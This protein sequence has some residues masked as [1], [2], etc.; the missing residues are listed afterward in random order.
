[1]VLSRF[2]LITALSIGVAAV[3]NC[4]RTNQ[5]WSQPLTTVAQIRRLSPSQLRSGFRAHLQGT[6]TFAYAS[7]DTCYAQDATGGVRVQLS[8]GQMI[9]EAGRRID[10]WGTVASAGDTPTLVE[11]RFTL[12]GPVPLPP[13]VP[14]RVDASRV[15]DLSFRRVSVTGVVQAAADD[16]TDLVI[17][18]VK[19]GEKLIP[20][21]V[22]APGFADPDSYI[23]ADIRINGVL[24]GLPESLD[25]GENEGLLV[26]SFADAQMVSRSKSPELV[27]VSAIGDLTRLRKDR[28][29]A[30]RVRVRGRAGL[31]SSNSLSLEDT[32][33]RITVL[34]AHSGLKQFTGMLD[35]TGFLAQ[36]GGEII[37]E[38]AVDA[39]TAP[40]ASDGLPVLH[41]ARAIHQLTG[42]QSLLRYPA[43]VRGVVTFTDPFNGILFVQDQTDGIFVSVDDDRYGE[44][45]PG[46]F[47]EV[48]G[49]TT[50]GGFAP[51]ITRARYLRL[52]RAAL[53]EPRHGELEDAFLGRRDCQWIELRGVI[54]SAASGARETLAYLVSGTHRVQARIRAEVPLIEPLVNSLVRVRGVCGALFNNRRQ[55]LGIV[56]YVPGRDF[57]QVE[58][59]ASK[60]PFALPVTP[61]ER[62]LQF[63]PE[64]AMGYRVRMRGVAT[65]T[66]LSGPTWVRDA[67]GAVQ[68]KDHTDRQLKPGDLVDV[69]GFP[70]QGPYSPVL[71]GG[72]IRKIGAGDPPHPTLLKAGQ[73]LNGNY[74]G[75]LIQ[76]DATLVDQ[77]IR[78]GGVLLSLQSGLTVFT[79][80]LPS[81]SAPILPQ[82]GSLVRLTGICSVLV[83]DSRD[84]VLPRAFKILLRSPADLVVLKPTPWLTFDR[85]LP[86]SAITL[87]IAS[88]ALLWASRLRRRVRAQTENLALKTADLEKAHLHTTTALRRAQ[89]AESMEQ[90]HKDVLELVARDEDLDDVVTRLARSIEDHCLGISC[91]IQLSLPGGKRLSA[92]PNLPAEWD[93]VLASTAIDGFC[94]DGVHPLSE[95]SGHAAWAALAESGVSGRLR[96][97][98]LVRIQRESRVIGAIVAF[99][100]GEISLRRSEQEF[101]NSAAKLA[102]LAVQRRVLYDQLSFRAR[103]D[104]LT[105]LENRATLFDKLSREIALA[106]DNRSLLG[107]IYIDLD[108]FKSINDTFGHPA[109]DAVLREVSS[110]M[111]AAIRRSDTLARLGGDEFCILLPSLG[112]RADAERV[113]L[114]VSESVTRPIAFCGNELT[115]GA[116]IGIS[117][118][119]DDG[120]DAESLLQSADV[121]MYREKG[122][123][124]STRYS[125][126]K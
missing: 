66:S 23:D 90:A 124:Q 108:N 34:P 70:S 65:F 8:E 28:L 115:V 27:P 85:L 60:D 96:R 40:P 64:A 97:F 106:A 109:G 6:I 37:V 10:L 68:V 38:N 79:A 107:I 103:H 1:M 18:E 88:A 26:P 121:L 47:I 59:V 7:S 98:C 13:A 104:E 111:L 54:Q 102:A 36:R 117:V 45:R 100:A 16:T 105:G 14:L 63:S 80:E 110:R 44:L 101:L 31:S 11:P 51:S 93:R 112:K 92:S 57:I 113:A 118:Y 20:V 39:V 83:D 74:D 17:M 77:S 62:L 122:N 71:T 91:S 12:L 9:A 123:R 15:H 21:R 84:T 78:P 29:P 56:I 19:A 125:F 35:L 58:Q 73:A 52:G 24:L 69:V 72:I 49:E 82:P 33:G 89:E 41:T 42:P 86:I 46:D 95:L 75:Q 53:P 120:D 48:H 99:L 5:D 114:V 25:S 43:K 32:S 94:D 126:S 119:P 61:V 3:T 55:L 116:S 81:R 67:T 22:L 50:A 87:V 76:V 4:G 30:H 2:W